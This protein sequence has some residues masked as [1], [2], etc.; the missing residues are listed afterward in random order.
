MKHFFVPKSVPVIQ[1]TAPK[2]HN[3][4]SFDIATGDSEAAT[5]SGELGIERVQ[6]SVYEAPYEPHQPYTPLYPNHEIGVAFSTSQKILNYPNF[7]NDKGQE[8]SD[9]EGGEVVIFESTASGK[10]VPTG[11][12]VSGMEREQPGLTGIVD[13]STLV[14]DYTRPRKKLVETIRPVVDIQHHSLP[15][16]SS[17]KNLVQLLE[18]EASRKEQETKEDRT[19]RDFYLQK[20]R[21]PRDS[22]RCGHVWDSEEARNSF[23]TIEALTH[24]LSQD[25]ELT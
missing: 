17:T 19:Y 15:H 23:L 22:R 1:T 25:L 4:G 5:I 9:R 16:S 21:T 11:G 24:D 20:P 13:I 6:S 7:H 2:L 10:I 18:K 8:K 14:P 3:P 12:G